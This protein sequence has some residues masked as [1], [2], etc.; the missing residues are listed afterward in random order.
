MFNG[1]AQVCRK[2]CN[3]SLK[4]A[5]RSSDRSPTWGKCPSQF[6]RTQ[7]W[8]FPTFLMVTKLCIQVISRS[9]SRP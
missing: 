6:S 9:E 2:R 4:K 3:L 5:I 7:T 8:V 1:H